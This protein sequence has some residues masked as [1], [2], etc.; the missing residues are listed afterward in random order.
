MPAS[1]PNLLTPHRT[2]AAVQ[3]GPVR[4]ELDPDLTDICEQYARLHAIPLRDVLEPAFLQTLL[5]LCAAATFISGPSDPGHREVESPQRVGRILNLALQ[6]P[7]CLR[8][9]EDATGC[10]PLGHIEGRLTQTLVRPGDELL[11]H[12]DLCEEDRR[13]AFVLNLGTAPYTGGD[14]ELRAKGGPT[15]LRVHHAEPGS[16]LIFK[17]HPR[18]EHR[19][20]PLTAGG[21]RRVFAGWAIAK[22]HPGPGA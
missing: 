2:F 15:L 6:R 12:D 7:N 4:T 20:L 8:W 21:P 11:W 22:P 9:L 16:A 10:V 17:V 19:V 14:F 1:E 3:V 5:R 13:L 18:I